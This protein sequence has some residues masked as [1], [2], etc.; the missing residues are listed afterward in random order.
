MASV[1]FEG[2]AYAEL[3]PLGAYS[4]KR[5]AHVAGAKVFPSE[6]GQLPWYLSMA[7]LG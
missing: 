3:G 4:A 6:A 7:C 5:Q 1:Y 2:E